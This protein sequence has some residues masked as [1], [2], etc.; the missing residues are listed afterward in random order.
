M[1]EILASSPC[2]D[3]GE[4]AARLGMSSR[5]C[6]RALAAAGTT[7]RTELNAGRMQRAR[8]LLTSGDRSM[9]WIA[10]EL[11]FASVQHFATAF[12]RANGETP[13]AWRDRNAPKVFADVPSPEDS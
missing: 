9:K 3:L 1:R 13:T 8:G 4:L 6:Q 5:S 2:K 10:G 7:F 12:R 11:G